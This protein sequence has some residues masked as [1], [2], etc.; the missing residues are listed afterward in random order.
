MREGA[1]VDSIKPS[2]YEFGVY[3]I[4]KQPVEK[5]STLHVPSRCFIGLCAS[6]STPNLT[7]TQQEIFVEVLYVRSNSE[8]YSGSKNVVTH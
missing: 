2:N 5:E 7:D 3:L 1:K 8:P 6:M 4:P